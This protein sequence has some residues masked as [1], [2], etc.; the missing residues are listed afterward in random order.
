LIPDNGLKRNSLLSGTASFGKRESGNAVYDGLTE[1]E[2]D[3]LMIEE[4]RLAGAAA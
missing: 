3:S 1:D 4:N 2:C